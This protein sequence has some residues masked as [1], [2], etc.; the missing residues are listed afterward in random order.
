VEGSSHGQMKGTMHL[1]GE[2]EANHEKPQSGQL[3]SRLRF[4]PPEYKAGVLIT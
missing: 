1:S 2:T 4:I 3:V